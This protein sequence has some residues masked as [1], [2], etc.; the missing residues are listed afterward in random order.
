[1]AWPVELARVRGEDIFLS[2]KAVCLKILTTQGSLGRIG[3]KPEKGTQTLM[4]GGGYMRKSIWKISDYYASKPHIH[5]NDT[6]RKRKDALLC[7][8]ASTLMRSPFAAYSFDRRTFYI[9]REDTRTTSMTVTLSDEVM[10]AEMHHGAACFLSENRVDVVKGKRYRYA[11]PVTNALDMAIS[12]YYSHIAVLEDSNKGTLDINKGV[13]EIIDL[14][15]ERS[16]KHALKGRAVQNPARIAST[17]H[18]QQ[19]VCSTGTDLQLIDLREGGSANVLLTGLRRIVDLKRANKTSF[20]SLS[21]R[22]VGMHDI[23]APRNPFDTVLHNVVNPLLAAGRHVV[24]Y[25]EGGHFLYIDAIEPRFQVH[26]EYAFPEKL[27]RFD[28]AGGKN[29]HTAFLF[30][31]RL[32]VFSLTG[33]LTSYSTGAPPKPADEADKLYSKAKRPLVR[34]ITNSRSITGD[35][36]FDEDEEKPPF[37]ASV[38]EAVGDAERS[39]TYR[40]LADLLGWEEEAAEAPRAASAQPARDAPLQQSQEEVRARLQ[41]KRP[42][43]AG[44]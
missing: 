9:R 30:W 22:H 25:N 7:V 10:K 19:Y 18:P 34:S 4:F 23:R 8:T 38:L 2:E 28:L 17:W 37:L 24:V 12:D 32:D 27:L 21:S 44:F 6:F 16:T 39:E 15:T 5:L 36:V 14:S 20:A 43:G 31:N 40:K 33:D 11:L 41:K 13:L 29:A 26:K 1:M 35:N 3:M 42:A